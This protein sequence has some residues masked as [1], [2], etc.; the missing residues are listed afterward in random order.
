MI[1]RPWRK[2]I[3]KGERE[4]GRKEERKRASTLCHG[5]SADR[6]TPPHRDI[7]VLLLEWSPVMLSEPKESMQFLEFCSVKGL[8]KDVGKVMVGINI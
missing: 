3:Y 7:C 2:G 8:R 1:K 6:N 5:V 4:K